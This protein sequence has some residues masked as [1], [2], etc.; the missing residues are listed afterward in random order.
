M[1]EIDI[2]LP[3]LNEAAALPY[4]LDRIPET[5]RAIVV[6]NGSTDGS[7]ALA[8]QLGATVVDSPIQGYGAACHAGLLAATAPYVAFCD[9]DGSLDPRDV[10]RLVATL[11]AGADLAI[12]RRRPAVRGAFPAPARV[13]NIELARQ[14][15]K[16]CGAPVR[17]VGPLRAARRT[18]LLELLI[19]DRRS[20]YPVETV[21]RAA[22]AGWRIVQ[23]DVDYH[24]R[25][26][27]SKV[28]GSPR[29]Y[30][31]AIRDAR[32]ALAS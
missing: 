18:A 11:A 19:A 24:P 1:V 17:D 8:S 5:A 12:C 20:G 21:V 32:T 15:R 22:R 30:L 28:T 7:A 14:V 26:G 23:V 3:C 27:R 31:T 9:C 25:I 16:R 2:V 4:V 6:D 13:A 10:L 29:G